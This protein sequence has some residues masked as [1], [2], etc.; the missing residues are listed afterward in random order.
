MK[1]YLYSHLYL[2]LKTYSTFAKSTD[3]E[4]RQLWKCE[5]TPEEKNFK[6]KICIFT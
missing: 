1:N 5:K 4:T 3:G 2:Q 6:K